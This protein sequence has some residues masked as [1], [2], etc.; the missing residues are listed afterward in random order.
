MGGVEVEDV[1]LVVLIFT[2][3]QIITNREKEVMI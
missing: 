1:H 3:C 2:A